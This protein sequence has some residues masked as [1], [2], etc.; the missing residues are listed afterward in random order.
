MAKITKDNTKE[1]NNLTTNV[2]VIMNDVGYIKSEVGEMKSCMELN[3]KNDDTYKEIVSHTKTLWDE[4][5]RV[6]G[7][8]LAC[9]VVGGTTGALIK[10]FIS[11]VLAK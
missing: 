8:L 7:W 6:I 4:R 11:G 10:Q 1:I 5:N 9:G 3:V 2:A